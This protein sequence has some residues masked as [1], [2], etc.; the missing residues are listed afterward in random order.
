VGIHI[1][2]VATYLNGFAE[3]FQE[4]MGRATSIYLPTSASP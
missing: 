1:T 2:D 3:I 4:A